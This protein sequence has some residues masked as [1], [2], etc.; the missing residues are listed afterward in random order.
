MNMKEKTQKLVNT[1][2][3][4][5]KNILQKPLTQCTVELLYNE[6]QE[7][8]VS[9]VIQKLFLDVLLCILFGAIGDSLYSIEVFVI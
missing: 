4:P 2:I 9:F 7:T 6:S 1:F 5:I 8:G 3:N